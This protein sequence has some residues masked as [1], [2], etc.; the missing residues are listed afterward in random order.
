MTDISFLG[1][2]SMG[3]TWRKIDY[4]RNEMI[5]FTTDNSILSL[6]S[7]QLVSIRIK[8]ALIDPDT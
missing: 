5:V 1:G 3:E 6:Q 2:D 4:E 8:Y 7:R